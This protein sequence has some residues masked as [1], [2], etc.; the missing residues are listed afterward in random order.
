MKGRIITFFLCSSI[1]I[2][3]P[4][5]GTAVNGESIDLS[6]DRII[7]VPDDY[8]TIQQAVDGASDGDTIIV[9]DGTYVENVNV[10]KSLT[11]KSENG[12]SRCVVKAASADEHVFEITANRASI[13]GFT[14][15]RASG[16]GKAGIYVNASYCN[17]LNNICSHNWDGINLY[18]SDNSMISNNICSHNKDDGISLDFSNNNVILNNNCSRNHDAGIY[19]HYSSNNTI[20]NNNCSLNW[21]GISLD[22]SNNKISNNE[23]LYNQ[24]DGIYLHYSSNNAISNNNCS[25]NKNDGIFLLYS[26]NNKIS[27]NKC[28]H[29][30]WAAI[31]LDRSNN[32]KL[33]GNRMLGCGIVIQ[34]LGLSNYTHEID[35]SNIVNGKPVYYWKNVNGGKIPEEA[36]QVILVNCSSV[37]V[38]NQKLNNASIGIQVAFSSHITISNNICSHNKDDGIRLV[39]SNSNIISNN[40]C[41]RN[42]GGITFWH[43][44]NNAVSTNDCSYN[45]DNGILLWY[46]DNNKISNNKCS[47]NW[48]GI[49]LDSSNS[50]TIS[51]NTC[52]HNRRGGL[53]LQYSNNNII[54]NNNCLCNYWDGILLRCSSNNIISNNNCSY[55]NWNVGIYLWY[56]NNNI[57]SN[58]NCSHNAEGIS[59]RHSN[60]NIIYLNNLISNGRN[61][62]SSRSRNVWNS[63]EKITYVYKGETYTNYLGNYFD[64]Y[65]GE[66]E[67]GDG[68]GDAPYGED[69]HPLMLPFENYVKGRPPRIKMYAPKTGYLY[70]SGKEIMPLPKSI[71]YHSYLDTVIVERIKIAVV[72]GKVRIK[73]SASDEHGISAIRI[74]VNGELKHQVF[75]DSVDWIWNERAFGIY[76]LAVEAEN[77]L[78]FKSTKEVK[79]FVINLFPFAE[80]H[81][82]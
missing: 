72:V 21:Y 41:F 58:N 52:S 59:L 61:V 62:Y 22:H 4:V 24:D 80:Y 12:P 18:Y 76:T 29:N 13:V 17:I 42:Q 73:A 49:F 33:E 60:S 81:T 44:S 3:G 1:V 5:I 10:Y 19:L 66:D 32:N 37:T 55:N 8:P 71:H 79:I 11:I 53:S 47:R 7:Y 48:Y 56:S 77:N 63:T 31:F 28:F 2:A 20:S 9:R 50:N 40:I 27:N 70:I 65:T 15:E 25:H 36:G 64:D 57:V 34:G 69:Q 39:F 38:E 46:S 51:N 26:N 74:Y 45:W 35:T 23:C 67:N 14:V 54:S 30:N 75:N 16:W 43:S 78:A 82:T 68:I 6:S